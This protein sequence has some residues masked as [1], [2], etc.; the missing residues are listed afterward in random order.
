M[1]LGANKDIR[2]LRMSIGNRPILSP[3]PQAVGNIIMEDDGA[4]IYSGVGE[5]DDNDMIDRVDNK[6]G[7]RTEDAITAHT[8]IK[9]KGAK[10]V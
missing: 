10:L 2:I 3:A 6:A 5:H 7:L 1:M 9:G 8:D 4:I